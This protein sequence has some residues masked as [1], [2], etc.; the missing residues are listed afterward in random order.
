MD[1][2]V[3]RDRASG[4]FVYIEQMERRIEETPWGYARRSV[5]REGQIRA[6]FSRENLEVII[7]WGMSSVGEVLETYPQHGPDGTPA[8]GG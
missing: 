5:R 8:E 1:L 6:S 2:L 4:R 7:G 3:V